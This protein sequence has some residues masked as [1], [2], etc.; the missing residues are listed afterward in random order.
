MTV[1][2]SYDCCDA[3]HAAKP[4]RSFAS[5]AKTARSCVRLHLFEIGF[6]S[7]I[8]KSAQQFSGEIALE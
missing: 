1:D 2:A 7:I 6:R 8:R 4:K 3:N 5:R